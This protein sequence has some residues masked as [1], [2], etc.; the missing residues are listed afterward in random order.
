M[1]KEFNRELTC[2]EVCNTC[3]VHV[4]LPLWLQ[5]WPVLGRTCLDLHRVDLVL[6][7]LLALYY[8]FIPLWLASY[9]SLSILWLTNQSN[10]YY[11]FLN[12]SYAQ[13]LIIGASNQ[14]MI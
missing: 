5:Y 14:G 12:T 10:M 2:M 8:F 11:Y 13:F 4:L 3:Y 6:A 9:T 1:I 7:Q